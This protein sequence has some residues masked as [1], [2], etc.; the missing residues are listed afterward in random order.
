MSRTILTWY[1]EAC[2]NDN[3]LR[4]YLYIEFSR[5]YVWNEQSQKW[6]KRQNII[7][8]GCINS[9]NPKDGE[10]FYLRLLL[11]H[12]RGPT[13][14]EDLLTVDGIHYLS[15][16]EA[17]EKRGLLEWD[18]SITEYL[19]EATTYQMPK[20]FRKLFAIILYHC[21][22]SNVKKLWDRFFEVMSEDFKRI[23]ED[24]FVIVSETLRSINFFLEGTWSFYYYYF[25]FILKFILFIW[26]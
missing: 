2:A 17:S 18:E 15:F 8:I 20:A 5:R 14:F 3:N 21:E 16:K 22:A 19:I 11:N 1:F 13:S 6:T 26:L 7:V 9:A 10:R 12:I 25:S 23:Y 24:N 4:N